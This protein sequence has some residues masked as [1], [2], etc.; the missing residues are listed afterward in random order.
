MWQVCFYDALVE[1]H[2]R[3]LQDIFCPTDPQPDEGRNDQWLG[4]TVRSQRTA[5]GKALA[6]AHRFKKVG[7]SSRWGLGICVTMTNELDEGTYLDPCAAKPTARGHGQYGF[8]QAGT[9]ADMGPEDVILGVPGPVNWRGAIFKNIVRNDLNMATF[10]KWYQSA[11]EDPLPTAPGPEPVVG[12]YSYLGMS[13]RIGNVLDG[14]KT[15]IGGAPRSHEHGQVLLFEPAL[16]SDDNTLHIT[17][18]HYLTGDQFGA[19]FGYDI[20]LVD[21]NSDG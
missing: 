13:S 4:V 11:V 2:V 9:S 3:H 8:C 12:F 18:D 14:K 1:W 16:N 21:F 15:Y 17:P 5:K 20:A 10:P 6:C 19:C 7:A